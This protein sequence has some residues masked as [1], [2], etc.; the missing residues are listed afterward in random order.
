MPEILTGNTALA[1]ADP[2]TDRLVGGGGF[3]RGPER[4]AEMGYLVAP[5][6]RQRGVATAAARLLAAQAFA[7]GVERISLRTEWENTASQRVA[8]LR[9]LA[10]RFEGWRKAWAAMEP[11]VLNGPS[12]NSAQIDGRVVHL[13]A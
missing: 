1:F 8:D 3:R 2:A 5:W 6:A 13:S 4:T 12:R 10:G 7:Q 9:E 11:D